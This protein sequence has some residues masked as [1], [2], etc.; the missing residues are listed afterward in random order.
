MFQPI[1]DQLNCARLPGEK[2]VFSEKRDCKMDE[3]FNARRIHTFRLSIS[4]K[5][6]FSAGYRACICTENDL[7]SISN[8][9]ME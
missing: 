8:K 1:P 6:S 9:T 3:V 5:H 4:I 2:Y 7:D